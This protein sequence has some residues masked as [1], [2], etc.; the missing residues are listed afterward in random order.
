MSIRFREGPKASDHEVEVKI[1]VSVTMEAG[2]YWVRLFHE[3]GGIDDW[4][5]MLLDKGG[6][7][8]E[9]GCDL[10]VDPKLVAQWGNAL[11]GPGGPV[12]LD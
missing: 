5:I 6:Q 7:L 2:W 10:P 9:A 8:R 3:N 11:P 4:Q 12:R 1:L